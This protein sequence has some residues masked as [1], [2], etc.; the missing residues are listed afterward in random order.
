MAT[1]HVA[2]RTII[3]KWFLYQ[4][5]CTWHLQFSR[6]GAFDNILFIHYEISYR[7]CKRKSPTNNNTCVSITSLTYQKLY[8]SPSLLP[9]PMLPSDAIRILTFVL[10]ISFSLW[11]T[12]ICIF[13]YTLKLSCLWTLFNLHISGLILY[14]Y[15]SM[16]SFFAQHYL[17]MLAHTGKVHLLFCLLYKRSLYEEDTVDLSILCQRIIG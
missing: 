11:F 16:I 5:S 6:M 14:M 17:S 13:K 10:I 7:Q 8:T 4:V 15:S 12:Y 1:D 3:V 2:Q 9:S